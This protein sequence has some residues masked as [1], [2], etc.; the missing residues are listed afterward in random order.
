MAQVILGGL[1]T[2]TLLNGFIVPVMYML[3]ANR[4]KNDKQL[5]SKL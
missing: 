3:T 4:A 2:S 5:D 1:T